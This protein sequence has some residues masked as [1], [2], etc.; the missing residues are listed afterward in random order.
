[1]HTF[2]CSLQPR[3]KNMDTSFQVFYKNFQSE[4]AIE[5]IIVDFSFTYH[6]SNELSIIV[7]SD[8]ET[9]GHILP[10]LVYNPS[11]WFKGTE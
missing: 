3:V 7:C 9:S 1:M 6:H 2:V 5:I 4:I 10:K 11:F 8:D